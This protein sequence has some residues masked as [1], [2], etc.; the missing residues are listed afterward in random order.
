MET[1]KRSVVVMGLEEEDGE[2][3]WFEDSETILYDTVMVDT[4]HYT[5]LTPSIPYKVKY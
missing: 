1:V 4:C 5:C 3:K 2:T